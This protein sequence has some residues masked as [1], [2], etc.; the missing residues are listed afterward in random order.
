LLK[1]IF[2]RENFYSVSNPWKLNLIFL[3]KRV[4]YKIVFCDLMD[5]ILTVSTA[6]IGDNNG[7]W[8]IVIKEWDL[9][10]SD[11]RGNMSSVLECFSWLKILETLY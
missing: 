1:E 6:F 8:K 5:N 4:S 11:V 10:F 3:I 9:L 7:E 2:L